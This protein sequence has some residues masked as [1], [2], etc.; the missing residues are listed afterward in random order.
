M[1]GVKIK[2]TNSGPK[3]AWNHIRDTHQ[4]IPSACVSAFSNQAEAGESSAGGLG[5]HQ[6]L[7]HDHLVAGPWPATKE[8]SQPTSTKPEQSFKSVHV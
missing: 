6:F 2:T 8:V 4:L 7:A 1:L 3:L 5:T